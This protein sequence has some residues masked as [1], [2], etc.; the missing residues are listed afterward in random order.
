MA[1]AL[2]RPRWVSGA[3]KKKSVLDCAAQIGKDFPTHTE[4]EFP[5]DV[6][7]AFRRTPTFARDDQKC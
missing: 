6:G 2:I 4:V 7:A 1:F 5:T 3:G